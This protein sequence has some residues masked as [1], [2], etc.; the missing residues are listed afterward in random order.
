MKTKIPWILSALLAV[1]LVVMALGLPMV[2]FTAFVNHGSRVARTMAMLTPGGSITANST[3]TRI[4][5]KASPHVTWRR[6]ALGGV[7]AVTAFAALVVTFMVMRALGI[8]PAGSLLAKGVISDRD[9]ILVAEFTAPASDSGLGAVVSEAVRMGLAESGA[10][11]VMQP[12]QVAGAL[13]RMQ[14]PVTSRLDRDLAREVAQ[15]E[16][17]K[18]I[19]DGDVTPVGA[20]FIVTVRLRGTDPPDELASYRETAASATDLVPAIDRATRKL[21]GKIGESLKAVR[22]TIPLERATTASLPALRKYSEGFRKN[23]LEQ[24]FAAAIPLLEEAISLDSNFALAYRQL[25][26]VYGNA[27]LRPGRA[28]TLRERAFQLRERLPELER[29]LVEATYYNAGAPHYD[30]AKSIAANERALAIDPTSASALNALALTLNGRGEFARAESLYKRGQEAHPDI[31]FFWFNMVPTQ[32]AL[33]KVGDAR[34]TLEEY[35]RRFPRNPQGVLLHV[36]VYGAEGQQDSVKATCQR[37]AQSAVAVTCGTPMPS[38]LTPGAR[39]SP[40]TSPMTPVTLEVPRSSP[41]TSR[42]TCVT[43]VC[44][45]RRPGR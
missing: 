15:R 19:V 12:T 34:R 10:V 20:G 38:T 31:A 13:T 29:W 36:L 33:G 14:R 27:G 40:V 30:R 3:M 2:L 28:D 9:Q 35:V 21:R 17:A 42:C 26:L 32:I 1:A 8:G 39:A 11:K 6:T 24:D 4:A 18:A 44:L 25:A 7:V 37:A 45:A 23:T 5:V 16:G 41:A 43:M 22:A